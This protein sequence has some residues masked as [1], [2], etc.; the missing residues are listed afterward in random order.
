VL[1]AVAVGG[2]LGASS[3]Y[4]VGELIPSGT[5]GFPWGTFWANIAGSFALGFLLA[6]MLARLPHS[7][8]RRSFVA[9]G[10]LGAFTTY[11]SFA[12][13]TLELARDG[14][15]SIALLYA[16]ASLA[17][18]I[19]TAW[20]GIACARAAIAGGP[21]RLAAAPTRQPA[22]PSSGGR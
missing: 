19:L 1:A 5:D 13:G 17:G 22:R 21:L 2:A 11:S 15:P 18:G 12:V 14:H 6:V 20:G 9:T 16:A 8:Y 7:R 4:A 3:R 10:F